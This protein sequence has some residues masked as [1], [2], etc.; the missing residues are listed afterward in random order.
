MITKKPLFD[1]QG[2][3]QATVGNYNKKILEFDYTNGL[4]DVSAYRITGSYEDSDT[5]RDHVFFKNLKPKPI[6][7]LEYFRP[8]QHQL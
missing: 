1:E 5:H 7:Y 3:L 4:N 8:D 2:Y 6:F